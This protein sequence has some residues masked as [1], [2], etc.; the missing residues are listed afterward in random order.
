MGNPYNIFRLDIFPFLSF[1]NELAG[2]FVDINT[3][4]YINLFLCPFKQRD[5]S[6]MTRVS[7][8]IL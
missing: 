6:V 2:D 7:N 8:S 4:T 1:N 5:M 3:A